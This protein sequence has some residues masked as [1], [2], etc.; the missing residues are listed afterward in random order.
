MSHWVL[1]L[2]R[3][4]ILSP[5][6][7][8]ERRI[9]IPRSFSGLCY[10]ILIQARGLRTGECSDIYSHKYE[11]KIQNPEDLEKL[12]EDTI[13]VEIALDNEHLDLCRH[14]FDRILPVCLRGT[15]VQANIW[16]HIA[17]IMN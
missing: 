8:V 12:K 7:V 6:M 13:Q 1:L 9:D 4:L 11:V 16:D 3:C 14:I 2:F 10:G 5:D 15:Q 17:Q